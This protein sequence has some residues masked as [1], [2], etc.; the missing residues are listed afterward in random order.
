MKPVKFN[1]DTHR[2]EVLGV[3]I[4]SVT[5]ILSRVGIIDEE[6]KCQPIGGSFDRIN[7]D[8]L[9]T[10]SLVGTEFHTVVAHL[11]NGT[12]SEYPSQTN[13]K[14][15]EFWIKHAEKF[16]EETKELPLV[17]DWKTANA[18]KKSWRYQTAAY[19][20]LVTENLDYVCELQIEP[21]LTE[22]LLYSDVYK[23][24]GTID[25]INTGVLTKRGIKSF[26]YWSVKIG[27][28]GYEIDKRNTKQHSMDWTVFLSAL[29]IYKSFSSC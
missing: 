15:F 23:Y 27:D 2:Y 28:S 10:A 17:L 4:P 26:Q 19:V 9:E 6:G 7:K 3:A 13:L 29:N 11:V 16:L 14:E 24:A 8:I 5:Q 12:L 21:E 18:F 25:L 20:N 22:V 1:P